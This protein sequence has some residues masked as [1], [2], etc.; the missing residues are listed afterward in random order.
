MQSRYYH[1][2]LCISGCRNA[3][4]HTAYIDLANGNCAARKYF[5]PCFSSRLHYFQNKNNNKNKN[6]NKIKNTYKNKNQ[7][8]TLFSG[9]ISILTFSP[10]CITCNFALVT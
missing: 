7:K 4:I 9:T 3:S 1:G 2:S 5:K 10:R 6:K 8:K